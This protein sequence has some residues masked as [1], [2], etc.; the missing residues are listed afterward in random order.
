MNRD[1]ARAINTALN[2]LRQEPGRPHMAVVS[3]TSPLTVQ[4]SGEP[5]DLTAVRCAS[6]TPVLDDTVLVL[7]GM[8][9]VLIVDVIVT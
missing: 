1:S 6:Y 5:T 2:A 9:P 7:V 4:V 8:G 3:S